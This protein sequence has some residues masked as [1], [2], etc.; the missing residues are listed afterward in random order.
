MDV[1][2]QH[3]YK[4]GWMA[5]QTNM[6]NITNFDQKRVVHVTFKITFYSICFEIYVLMFSPLK[7]LDDMGNLQIQ[8]MSISTPGTPPSS[9]SWVY[10]ATWD[11]L[12]TRGKC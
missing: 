5:C 2:F 3:K 1:L 6:R 11:F 9:L 7:T 12:P 4:F 8:V 10:Q